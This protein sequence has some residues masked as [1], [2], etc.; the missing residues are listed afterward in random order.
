MGNQH[1]NRGFTIV[2]LLIV[3]VIIGIL[4]AIVIVAYTGITT[5]AQVSAITSEAKAWQKLFEAY[6]AQNGNYPSPSATPSSGGGPGSSA[7][8]IYCL[9]TGFPKVSGT[10]YCLDT[11]MNGYTVAESTG[12]SLMTQLSTVGTP[13][14]DTKKYAY[15]GIVGP[16]LE[17]ISATEMWI[18]TIYPPG[19]TCP[20]GLKYNYD[21]SIQTQCYIPL[22]GG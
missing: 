9:G 5:R 3:I 19:T 11:R 16:V 2:E 13:P 12:A 6:K 10:G 14:K 15:S 1:K 22:L 4:A 7:F 8:F 20:S 21:D 18:L 17:Y